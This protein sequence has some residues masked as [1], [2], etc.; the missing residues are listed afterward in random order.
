MTKSDR[1]ILDAVNAELDHRGVLAR[2]RFKPDE[3]YPL[4][5]ALDCRLDQCRLARILT[6]FRSPPPRDQRPF[7]GDLTQQVALAKVCY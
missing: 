3:F 5:H 7:F 4:H 1:A 2:K 6:N